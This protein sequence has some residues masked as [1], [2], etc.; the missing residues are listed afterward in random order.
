VLH[1]RMVDLKAPRLM[2]LVNPLMSMIVLPYLGAAAAG[3]ELE[4]PEEPSPKHRKATYDSLRQ[5]N[6]R[7]TYRTMRVLSAIG[8]QPGCSN[9]Q[10]GRA[11][12]VEDAGQMSKLL[13]RL[14]G[15]GLIANSGPSVKGA[16]NSWSLTRKGT[17]VNDAIV[18]G[19]LPGLS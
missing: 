6:I 5:L 16:P 1:R 10:V 15:L 17:E 7:L 8:A 13:G 18:A 4:Q 2:E 19:T 14:R 11:A 9:R 12:G 3:A